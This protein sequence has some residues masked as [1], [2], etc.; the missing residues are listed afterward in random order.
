VV[1]VPLVVFVALVEFDHPKLKCLVVF[2][3]LVVLEAFDEFDHPK[4]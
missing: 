1:F 3:P 2:V 4:L